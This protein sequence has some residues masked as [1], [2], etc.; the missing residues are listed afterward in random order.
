MNPLMIA[1]GIGI[2]RT[3]LNLLPTLVPD[4]EIAKRVQSI[5]TLALDVVENARDADA[6]MVTKLEAI[7]LE[8]TEISQ[9]GI[10]SDDV[11]QERER[12]GNIH[13]D[14]QALAE[15][16]KARKEADS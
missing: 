9:R 10:T 15:K 5:G 2:A 8:I 14:I 3:A 11:Q 7:E 12:L 13:D 16:A 6:A 4:S 1:R